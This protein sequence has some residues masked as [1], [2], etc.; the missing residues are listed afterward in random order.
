MQTKQ[1]GCY[2]SRYKERGLAQ[3]ATCWWLSG[4]ALGCVEAV[5][6]VGAIW[7]RWWRLERDF[8]NNRGFNNNRVSTCQAT[9]MEV[10]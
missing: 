3:N 10:W 7:W 8:D 1:A 6:A 2:K 4:V 9:L 5:E